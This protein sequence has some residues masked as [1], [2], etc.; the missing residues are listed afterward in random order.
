MISVAFLGAPMPLSAT[1]SGQFAAALA[2]ALGMPATQ[3]TTIAS[4][5][6]VTWAIT[7]P[8]LGH[9]DFSSSALGAA[10]AGAAAVTCSLPA[11]SV[12]VTGAPPCRPMDGVRGSETAAARAARRHD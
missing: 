6:A 10:I 11:A 8:G 2:M 5:Y 3:V 1:Q 12:F 9:A 7:I 4:G